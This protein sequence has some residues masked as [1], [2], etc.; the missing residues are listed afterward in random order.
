MATVAEWIEGARPRTLPNALAP[1]IA[2]SGVAAQL[3]AFSWW[4]MLLAL[5]VALSL[6][7][8]VN[9]ANDYSDGVRGT[10]ADRVG[11]LRL[12]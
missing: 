5:L 11:P 9:F 8:G 4:R 6:I 10:D 12:V 3:D 7:I 1:V 2:G